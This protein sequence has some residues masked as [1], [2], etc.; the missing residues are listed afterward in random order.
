MNLG[1]KDQVVIVTGG[2]RGIGRA[3]VQ[4]FLEEGAHVMI[5]SIRPSSVEAAVRELSSQGRVEGIP[6]DV[7]NEKDVTRL[8]EETVRRLGPPDVMVANAGIAGE[9]V[10]LVDMSVEE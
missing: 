2:S 4:A 3:T 10:N 8:V 9:A 1:F 5:S 6:A 7:A